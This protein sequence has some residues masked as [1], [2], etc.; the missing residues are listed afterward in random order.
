MEVVKIQQQCNILAGSIDAID[1]NSG[2]DYGGGGHVHP[3]SSTSSESMPLFLATKK[4]TEK[5]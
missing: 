1:G 3:S 5:N 4:R 2:I